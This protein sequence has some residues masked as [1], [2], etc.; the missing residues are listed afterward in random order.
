MRGAG[1]GCVWSGGGGGAGVVVGGG[2]GAPARVRVTRPGRRRARRLGGYGF[3]GPC[4]WGCPSSADRVPE[5]CSRG[6]RA[7]RRGRDRGGAGRTRSCRGRAAQDF[8][9]L[10][11]ILPLLT[12][13]H[14]LVTLSTP[15]SAWGKR[16]SSNFPPQV[17][18]RVQILCRRIQADGALGGA[19]PTTMA[20]AG[21]AALAAGAGGA[22]SAG[23]CWWRGR[24]WGRQRCREVPEI[25]EMREMSEIPEVL[26]EV[27]M[28]AG[29]AGRVSVPCG[30]AVRGGR[31]RVKGTERAAGV[32]GG[33]TSAR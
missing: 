27:V 32:L 26:E 3:A 20:A 9:V 4:S 29:A 14:R 17:I 28:G 11:R 33:I 8:W 15:G 1:R 6:A 22:G 23:E 13:C 19:A 24:F 10:G 31:C 7:G 30:G 5:V 2:G 21:Q 12:R 25:P 16:G 18:G